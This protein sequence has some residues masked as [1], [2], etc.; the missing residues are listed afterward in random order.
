MNLG[1]ALIQLK[2]G[3]VPLKFGKQSAKQ[4]PEYEFQRLGR[5]LGTINQYMPEPQAK[6]EE[7]LN[8]CV[9]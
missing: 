7:H 2:V 8:I 9:F 1:K 4:Q 6:G 3:C 5:A